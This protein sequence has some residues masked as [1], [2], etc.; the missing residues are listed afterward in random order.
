M[1]KFILLILM[2]LFSLAAL[3]QATFGAEFTFT[4]AAVLAFRVASIRPLLLCYGLF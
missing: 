2:Q 1:L 3:A 4:N